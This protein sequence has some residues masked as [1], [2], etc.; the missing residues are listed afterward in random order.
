MQTKNLL[1]LV[2]AIMLFSC[3]KESTPQD[4][5]PQKEPISREAIT[6]IVE[7]TLRQ[8]QVFNWN[9]VDDFT[10]W[11]AGHQSDGFFAIGRENT[12]G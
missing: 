1:L 10:L 9:T 8:G 5:S 11:S 6:Q 2:F 4:I 7:E 12:C 3:N